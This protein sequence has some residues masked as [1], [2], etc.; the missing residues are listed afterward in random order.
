MDTTVQGQNGPPEQVKGYWA[1]ISVREG[2]A[3][4]DRMVIWNVFS[5]PPP[6]LLERVTAAANERQ[7]SQNTF[8]AYRR[9]WLKAIGGRP[10]RS[11]PRSL[12]IGE[13]RGV[14]RGGDSRAERFPSPPG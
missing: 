8:T 1:S 6:N 12:A 2:D 4:K 11:C 7:L 5:A 13:G 9:T 14:L 3:W 10:S